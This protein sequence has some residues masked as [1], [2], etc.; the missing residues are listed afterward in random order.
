MKRNQVSI[1]V[2]SVVLSMA[3]M[4]HAAPGEAAKQKYQKKVRPA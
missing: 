3:L 4:F 2:L 1:I